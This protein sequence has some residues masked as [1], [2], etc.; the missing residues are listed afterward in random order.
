MFCVCVS[1]VGWVSVH[2]CVHKHNQHTMLVT[3][4]ENIF[5]ILL[6]FVVLHNRQDCC[7]ALCPLHLEQRLRPKPLPVRYPDSCQREKGF[8]EQAWLMVGMI[9]FTYVSLTKSSSMA[10]WTSVEWKSIKVSHK[11]TPQWKNN[12]C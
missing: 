10:T 12:M 8:G 4:Y 5:T 6:V 1:C 2:I 7:P 11:G 3:R 9:S